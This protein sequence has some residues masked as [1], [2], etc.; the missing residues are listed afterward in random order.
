MVLSHGLMDLFMMEILRKVE[1]M[2]MGSIN[3]TKDVAMMVN[4]K[5]IKFM[6]GENTNGLM[7]G[8]LDR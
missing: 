5:T 1:N 4:G 6:D 8:Y 2:G 3:G 7:E